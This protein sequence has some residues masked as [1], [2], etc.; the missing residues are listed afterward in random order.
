M[1]VNGSA[2]GRTNTAFPFTFVPTRTRVFG[3]DLRIWTY[4]VTP[5]QVVVR[6]S[7]YPGTGVELGG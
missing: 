4:V 5:P 6:A 7:G 1:P 2:V 3:P